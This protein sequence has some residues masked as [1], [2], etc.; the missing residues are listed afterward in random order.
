MA[1]NEDLLDNSDLVMLDSSDPLNL[2]INNAAMGDGNST[3]APP[4]WS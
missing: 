2:I 1:E 4:D 3:E